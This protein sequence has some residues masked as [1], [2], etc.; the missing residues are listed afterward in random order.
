MNEGGRERNITIWKGYEN[1]TYTNSIYDTKSFF[2]AAYRQAAQCINEIVRD[3]ILYKDNNLPGQSNQ[4]PDQV[5][6]GY[7]NNV[8]A[9]CAKRGQGKTSAMLSMSKALAKMGGGECPGARAFWTGTSE[10]EKESHMVHSHSFCVIEPID[11]TTMERNDSVLRNILSRLFNRFCEIWKDREKSSYNVCGYNMDR[12]QDMDQGR[13]SL[14]RKFSTCFQRLDELKQSPAAN[15]EYDD[16]DRLS[17]VGDSVRMKQSLSDL[18]MEFLKF[19]GF[20]FLVIQIDDADLNTRRAYEIVEDIRRYCVVP[21]V[22]ILMAVHL[23]TLRSC[24]E[25]Q[26]V[27]SYRHLLRT[28]LD[29]E[30][31]ERFRCREMAERYIDKL[32][33]GL[34]QVHLPYVEDIIRDHSS[35]PNIFYLSGEGKDLLAYWNEEEKEHTDPGKGRLQYENRLFRLI[36]EKTGVVLLPT[37]SYM[38]NF[39]PTRFRELTHFLSV[40]TS[41]EDVEPSGDGSL[42]RLLSLACTAPQDKED[43]QKLRTLL[44]R[45][46][47]N[48]EAMEV[49]FIQHWCAVNFSKSETEMIVEIQHAPLDVKHA[50]TLRCLQ[51]FEMELEKSEGTDLSTFQSCIDHTSPNYANIIRALNSLKRKGTEKV[52]KFV[53]AVALYYTIYMNKL[54]CLCLDQGKDLRDLVNFCGRKLFPKKLYKGGEH[55]GGYFE[56]GLSLFKLAS[57]NK[58]FSNRDTDW[59]CLASVKVNGKKQLLLVPASGHTGSMQLNPREETAQFDIFNILFYQLEN[60]LGRRE[61]N[62]TLASTLQMICNYDIQYLVRKYCLEDCV[63]EES[64]QPRYSDWVASLFQTI[65]AIISGEELV[66]DDAVQ[67]KR[68]VLI[69]R[70]AMPPQWL[71]LSSCFHRLFDSIVTSTKADGEI[72]Q[73]EA[74]DNVDVRHAL[75]A[76]YCSQAPIHK[77]VLLAAVNSLISSIEHTQEQYDEGSNAADWWESVKKGLLSELSKLNEGEVHGFQTLFFTDGEK[78]VEKIFIELQ[79]QLVKYDRGEILKNQLISSLKTKLERLRAIKKKLVQEKQDQKAAK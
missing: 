67:E 72:E 56:F 39:V 20:D 66:V 61:F 73:F 37:N 4:T 9:F 36:Y 77:E 3:S 29:T 13:N 42:S 1:R 12:N 24:I 33:P 76:M 5:L 44:R 6:M 48:L 38:H 14:L 74:N 25:Q 8:V 59:S 31:L 63:G 43:R 11:P 68:R 27:I 30:H 23:G 58:K 34:H 52:Y 55:Q 57:K 22:V 70:Y 71:P 65:D 26:F 18:V 2:Y 45:R 53:Y 62:E 15:Q 69:D 60:Y 75:D 50:K 19:T 78:D 16:L 32:L 21:N 28:D 54:V 46:I 47:R 79:G 64:D 10:A 7:P 49:Y 35:V 51:R 41:L 40:F 17:E